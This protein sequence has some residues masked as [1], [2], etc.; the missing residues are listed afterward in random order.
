MFKYFMCIYVCKD[1]LWFCNILFIDLAYTT[2]VS[3][4]KQLI[5]SHNTHDVRENTDPN[6]RTQ[7]IPRL[8]L[9][10]ISVYMSESNFCSSAKITDYTAQTPWVYVMCTW[11]WHGQ[12]NIFALI[13]GMTKWPSNFSMVLFWWLGW[14]YHYSQQNCQQYTCTR[15]F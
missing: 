6:K 1:C 12:K 9:P 2:S 4:N 8:K 15:L 13:F 3:F 11:T 7:C 14:H 5:Y 10:Q